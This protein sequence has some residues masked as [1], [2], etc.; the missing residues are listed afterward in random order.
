MKTVAR[1][2]TIACTDDSYQQL[3][4]ENKHLTKQ[5]E[6]NWQ[7]ISELKMFT[8]ASQPVKS[9]DNCQTI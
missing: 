5:D 7:S 4:Y 2:R 8:S 1:Q 9:Y 3:K 6:T